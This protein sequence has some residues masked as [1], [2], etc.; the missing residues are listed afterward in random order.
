[1]KFSSIPG[2]NPTK[3]LLID[4]VKNNHTAHAQLFVGADGA[5]NLPLALAYATYLHCLNRGEDDACGTCSACSKNLKFI[6]PD[7]H[8][9]FPLSNIK[10]DK[11]EERFKAEIMKSWRS[12]L[13]EQPFGNLNDWTSFYGGEDKQALI[14]RDE[15]R[16]IIKTLSLKPFESQYKVMIIWQPELMHPSAANGI[17]KILEEPAAHTYFILITNAAD[18]LLPTIISRTQIVSIPMLE[19]VEVE[20][21]LIGQGV[22][23][24]KAKKIATLA[25]G[26]INVALKSIDSSED[27]NTSRFIEWMRA[28]FKKSYATLVS[29]SEGY[30]A[31]D[32]LSQK[33]LMAYSMNILRETLLTLSGANTINR[34]QGEE[35]KFVQDFS[36]VMSVEKIDKSFMLMNE[37]SYHLERNGSAKMIFLDLSLKLSKIINP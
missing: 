9:V 29:L 36:K 23:Q 33:N 4:A 35:L 7:T 27:D 6:H 30:H 37:A 10:G 14:S 18:K 25:E 32:K 20:N 8:F 2:L 28:C 34:L 11:D 26:N 5:L 12:F 3:K 16:E 21:Q 15:S 24:G 17:L 13:L 31:L 19:D 1:M 22:E